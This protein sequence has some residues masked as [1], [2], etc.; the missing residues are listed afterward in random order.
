MLKHRKISPTCPFVLDPLN[1]GNIAYNKDQSS[2]NINDLIDKN[3][4]E[5]D[6]INMNDGLNRI[7]TYMNDS[8]V[9]IILN[10]FYYNFY[11]KNI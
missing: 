3:K 9:S 1:S 11:L 5:C 8:I 6:V 4:K 10:I 7:R 2:V